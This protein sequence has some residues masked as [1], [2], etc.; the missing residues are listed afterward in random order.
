MLV[1]S[2][3]KTVKSS[4]GREEILK[5]NSD[6]I[7]RTIKGGGCHLGLLT[8]NLVMTKFIQFITMFEK[9]NSIFWIPGLFLDCNFSFLDP[10]VS[11]SVWIKSGW[12]L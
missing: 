7:L 1:S 4:I 10:G 6:G 9:Y 5:W 11:Q 2:K 3:G 8:I 12:F